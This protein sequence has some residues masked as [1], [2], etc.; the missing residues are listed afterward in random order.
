MK[1]HR[2]TW[3]FFLVFL[4]FFC[5]GNHIMPITDP[6]ES[7]YALTAKEMLDSGNW[8]SPQIYHQFWYD[9]PIMIYWLVAA[10]Y[11][12]FGVVDFAARFPSALFGALSV[13]FMYQMVRTIA[14]RRLLAVW[15][16]L[17]LGT[18]LEFW[19]IGHA[20]ITDM[21]LMF[22][23]IGTFGYAYRGLMEKKS[24][25]IALAYFFAGLGV[26]TKGPVAIVLPGILFLIFAGWS[27]SWQMVKQLFPV[28]GILIFLVTV[29]PWYGYM[30]AAHGSDFING[31]LGL[32]NITRAT[33]SEHPSDNHW[34]YYLA[35]FLGASLPWT[36]A[37]IYGMC[38]GWRERMPFYRYSMVCGWGTV[39][40]YTIM[41]TKYPTYTFISLIPFSFLGAYGCVKLLR[42]NSNRAKWWYLLGPALIMWV[43]LFIGSFFVKWGFWYG[44][45]AFVILAIIFIGG[46]YMRRKRNMIPMAIAVS[47]MIISGMVIYEGL[48]PLMDM[49][50]SK[51]IVATIDEY[52]DYHLYYFGDYSTSIPYY[53]GRDMIRIDSKT[54]KES[55]GITEERS[56]AWDAKYTMPFVHRPE[57][58]AE[59]EAGKK[60]LV[61]IPNR[62]IDMFLNHPLGQHFTVI[63]Q[64]ARESIAIS[65][66]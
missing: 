35:I 54:Y 60:V 10:S 23:T 63:A 3:V 39:V 41:A 12:I 15:S 9:K 18:S 5:V 16:A 55:K 17:I 26:L 36:G 13:A 53:T 43:A 34:W 44:F 66:K 28:K 51:Q 48:I 25:F 64:G 29:L 7:N 32:H 38:H 4:A 19:V 24:W 6:V 56:S 58:K 2:L 59:V 1:I 45:D 46:C 61:I 50:S 14:N 31:F 30:Y 11:A 33:Q 40:F 27:Q 52:P 57:L 47:T 37:V 20:V 62:N 49:R 65:N 8:L 22:T 21:I 42:A